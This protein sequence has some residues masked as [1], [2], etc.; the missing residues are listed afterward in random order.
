MRKYH[1]WEPSLFLSGSTAFLDPSPSSLS[2]PP[3]TVYIIIDHL[4]F[5]P[6]PNSQAL[7]K[8]NGDLSPTPAEQASVL[9][10]VT[11]IQAVMDNLI[12]D[13]G[14]FDACVSDTFIKKYLNIILN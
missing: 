14:S 5:P 11:K 2:L 10:L 12:V 9:N 1:W 6:L 13:P 8:R 3:F 4:T 7:L